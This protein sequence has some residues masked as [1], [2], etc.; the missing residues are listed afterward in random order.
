MIV[1]LSKLGE[2]TPPVNSSLILQNFQPGSKE[3]LIGYTLLASRLEFT[4]ALAQTRAEGIQRRLVTN[5]LMPQ[6]LLPGES[7]I[8]STITV[9]FLTTGLIRILRVSLINGRSMGPWSAVRTLHTDL[10]STD[11][12][13]HLP[14]TRMQDMTGP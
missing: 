10:T 13:V 9:T 8:S 11:H 1:G 3:L 5:N 14:V 12:A 2:I 6:P 4:V 7:T